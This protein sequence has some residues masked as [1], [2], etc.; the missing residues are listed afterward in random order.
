MQFNG[1]ISLSGLIPPTASAHGSGTLEDL[2]PVASNDV[3]IMD[4]SSATELQ[5]V[6]SA[7]A[8]EATPTVSV[9]EWILSTHGCG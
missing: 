3:L 1:T 6:L 5:S 4:E 2:A 9:A 8:R 7:L